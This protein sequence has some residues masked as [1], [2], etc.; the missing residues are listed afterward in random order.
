MDCLEFRRRLGA[1]P[2]AR[3]PALL[4]HRD[5]CAACAAAWERAQRFER[6]LLDALTV[7]EPESLAERV[8][9]AQAT[10]ERQRH[11]RRRHVGFAIAASLLVVVAGSLLTWRQVDAHSLPALAVAHVA[12]EM[13]AFGSTGPVPAQAVVGD[14]AARGA[15]LR[16]PV[17]DGTTFVRDCDVGSHLAVHMVTRRDGEPVAVLYFPDRRV[18]A[19]KDFRR[20]GWMGREVPTRHGT[21]LLLADGGSMRLLAAVERDWR[22]AIDGLDGVRLSAL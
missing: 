2:H 18:A 4:A 19:A 12:A 5:G 15:T 20:Q 1:D 10:G 7:P 8:L 17:P 14:F 9:L 21:L 11:T 3:D 13:D 22:L 6:D 16:G